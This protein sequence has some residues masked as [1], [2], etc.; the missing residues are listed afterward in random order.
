MPAR[1][2][3]VVEHPINKPPAWSTDHIVGAGVVLM[4]FLALL[5]VLS[6]R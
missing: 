6:N 2:I 5:L 1:R 3:D 4:A